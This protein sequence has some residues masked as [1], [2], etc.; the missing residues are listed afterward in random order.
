M[1]FFSG[2][3]LPRFRLRDF[4]GDRLL[5]GLRHIVHRRHR[6]HGRAAVLRLDGVLRI[7][8]QLRAGV[9]RCAVLVRVSRLRVL[10]RFQHTRQRRQVGSRIDAVAVDIRSGSILQIVNA[11][12]EARQRRVIDPV[13][14]ADWA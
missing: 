6:L 5:N 10:L 1:R 9:H 11:R 13:A 8:V 14:L 7:C 4:T 12:H 3:L 2:G